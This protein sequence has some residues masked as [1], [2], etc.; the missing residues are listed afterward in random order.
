MYYICPKQNGNKMKKNPIDEA[1]DSTRALVRYADYKRK[2]DGSLVWTENIIYTSDL[3]RYIK[4]EYRDGKR[5]FTGR[6]SV[7]MDI[8]RFKKLYVLN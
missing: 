6:R 8:E 5:I 7:Y 1:L 4:I 2:S 3:V